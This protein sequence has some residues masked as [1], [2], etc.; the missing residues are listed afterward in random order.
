MPTRCRPLAVLFLACCLLGACGDDN[1]P[2]APATNATSAG[3]PS[4]PTTTAGAPTGST[5]TDATETTTAGGTNA[6]CAALKDTLANLTVNWQVIIGLV[7]IGTSEWA[8][9]PLGHLE[10]FGTQLAAASAALGKNLQAAGALKFMAGANE[11][12]KRGLGGD[13]T[14]QADLATYLGPDTAASINKQLPIGLA[15]TQ[16]GCS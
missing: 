3:A 10:D 14:A 13:T 8:T 12:V 1:T 7:N 4:A 2:A 15:Y 9:L 16:T 5:A 6:N 11:I